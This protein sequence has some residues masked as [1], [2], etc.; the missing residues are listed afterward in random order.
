MICD[1]MLKFYCKFCTVSGMCAKKNAV[2]KDDV[3]KLVDDTYRCVI[4]TFCK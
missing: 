2:G 3:A 4:W 1:Y